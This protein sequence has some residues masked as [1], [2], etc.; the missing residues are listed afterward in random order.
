MNQSGQHSGSCPCKKG[1]RQGNQGI[2][3]SLEQG[4]SNRSSQRKGSVHGQVRKVQYPV[5]KIYPQ[6]HNRISQAFLQ[7]SCYNIRHAFSPPGCSVTISV[8]FL[9]L[10]AVRI[11]P[12][13]P[14]S[15]RTFPLRY[16]SVPPVWKS[17]DFWQQRYSRK[18]KL[19]Y[20]P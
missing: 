11:P 14:L 17:R 19:P 7:Y 18:R 3:T 1:N 20:I 4:C 9:H 15:C 2:H 10:L 12:D 8:I 13:V 5:S 6:R 16:R